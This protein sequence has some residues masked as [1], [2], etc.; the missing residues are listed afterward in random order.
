MRLAYL[1]E[2]GDSNLD[3][4]PYLVVAGVILD[5]DQDWQPL[6]RHLESIA[7]RYLPSKDQTRLFSMLK[8][9]GMASVTSIGPN[10]QEKREIRF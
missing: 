2:T 9:F 10:G 1:D 6:K 7:R 8:A 5:G 3:H 4:E